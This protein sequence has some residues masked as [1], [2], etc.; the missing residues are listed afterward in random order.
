M[1]SGDTQDLRDGQSARKTRLRASGGNRTHNPRI[2]NAVLCQLKLRWRPFQDDRTPQISA[3]RP[4]TSSLRRPGAGKAKRKS[5]ASDSAGASCHGHA[6]QGQATA[7][8]ELVGGPTLSTWGRIRG[9]LCVAGR[10]P[11]TPKEKSIRRAKVDAGEGL[12]KDFPLDRISR[13]RIGLLP[14]ECHRFRRM[15][16]GLQTARPLFDSATLR[17]ILRRLDL[18]LPARPDQPAA[19]C[20]MQWSARAGVDGV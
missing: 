14:A 9:K 16:P 6:G 11:A 17:S 19:N 5:G 7:G 15:G 13:G 8:P 4:P 18:R 20:M 3:A 12:R 2:T 1:C 10:K